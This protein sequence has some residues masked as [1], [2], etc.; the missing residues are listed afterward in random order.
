MILFVSNHNA[1]DETK[2]SN[3]I[4]RTFIK[5]PLISIRS[6]NRRATFS[7]QDD[8]SPDIKGN[9]NIIGGRY[10]CQTRSYNPDVVEY[11]M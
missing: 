10:Q 6:A 7:S 1:L 8:V 4:M 11:P 9:H 2:C 3:N 5:L